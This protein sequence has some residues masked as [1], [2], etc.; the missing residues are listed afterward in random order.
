[1]VE[2]TH[3]WH[4]RIRGKLVVRSKIYTRFYFSSCAQRGP[5]LRKMHGASHCGPRAASSFPGART[6]YRPSGCPPPAR[7]SHAPSTG[8]PIPETPRA[9]TALA[10]DYQIKRVSS[11]REQTDLAQANKQWRWNVSLLAVFSYKRCFSVGKFIL[12]LNIV[13]FPIDKLVWKICNTVLD[14]TYI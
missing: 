6:P 3:P 10:A 9:A 5:R 4:W 12:Y 1:M 7:T 11:R 13:V 14:R 2:I 8:R